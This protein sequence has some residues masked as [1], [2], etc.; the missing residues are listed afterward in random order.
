MYRYVYMMTDP[1]KC[2]TK[3]I[4]F[5]KK[6]LLFF[7]ASQICFISGDRGQLIDEIDMIPYK[8]SREW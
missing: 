2:F 7:F 5:T 6:L 3:L 4:E 1:L 8:G